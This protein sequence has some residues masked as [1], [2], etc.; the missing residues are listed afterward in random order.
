MCGLS[1]IQFDASR[2]KTT[3]V[4]LRNNSVPAGCVGAPRVVD[5]SKSTLHVETPDMRATP[6]EAYLYRPGG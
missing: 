3:Y 1:P 2:A 6:S 4:L 5:L